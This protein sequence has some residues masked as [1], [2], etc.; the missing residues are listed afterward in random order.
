MVTEEGLKVI[1]LLNHPPLSIEMRKQL[2][3]IV[4]VVH[5]PDECRASIPLRIINRVRR[6]FFR[7]PVPRQNLK[8]FESISAR[9]SD[10]YDWC[11]L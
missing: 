8:E 7:P 4:D 3:E 6:M 11:P 2:L 5:T 10:T 1:L 9:P